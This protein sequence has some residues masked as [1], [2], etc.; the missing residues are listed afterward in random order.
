M[1][2]TVNLQNGQKQD[3]D[4]VAIKSRGLGRVINRA[5]AEQKYLTLPLKG[6]AES[7]ILPL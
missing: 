7:V 5:G 1:L 2:P 6:V 3:F 4:T